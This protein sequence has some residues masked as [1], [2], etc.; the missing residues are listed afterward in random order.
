MIDMSDYDWLWLSIWVVMMDIIIT[1]LPTH[2][3]TLVG[4]TRIAVNFKFHSWF[5][6]FK[7]T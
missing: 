1:P 3:L 4:F 7:L 2:S 6:N 5:A